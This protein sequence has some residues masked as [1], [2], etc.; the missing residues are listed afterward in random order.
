LEQ[1][2]GQEITALEEIGRQGNA[3]VTV[4]PGFI[5]EPGPRL[6]LRRVG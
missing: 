4:V 2:F 3:D 6:G 5:S 1:V